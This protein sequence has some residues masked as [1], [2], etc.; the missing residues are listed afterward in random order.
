MRYYQRNFRDGEY[1]CKL[2]K[3]YLNTPLCKFY[4]FFWT[5]FA[6]TFDISH[7]PFCDEPLQSYQCSQTVQFFGPPCIYWCLCL[8]L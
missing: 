3:E 6:Q 1:L 8:H 5:K 7:A 4:A 2:G